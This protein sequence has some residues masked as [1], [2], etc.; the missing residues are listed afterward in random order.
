MLELYFR[1]NDGV[2]SDSVVT[3]FDRTLDDDALGDGGLA[4]SP[5]AGVFAWPPVERP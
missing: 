4:E 2:V 3:N 1:C 5:E